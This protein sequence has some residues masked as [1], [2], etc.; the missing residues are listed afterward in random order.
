MKKLIAMIFLASCI[1]LGGCNSTLVSDQLDNVQ[2]S[3]E[4]RFALVNEFGTDY[5]NDYTIIVDTETGVQYIWFEWD[6]KYGVAVPLYNADGT[7]S[8]VDIDKE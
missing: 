8:T 4:G 6:T 5:I 2:T 3:D 1:G 7:V